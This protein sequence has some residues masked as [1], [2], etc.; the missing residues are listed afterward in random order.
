MRSEFCAIAYG[1][2]CSTSSAS[3]AKYS[4]CGPA[5]R[6][7]RVTV[8]Q[9]ERSRSRREPRPARDRIAERQP[10]AATQRAPSTP[11]IALTSASIGCRASARRDAA[12][13]ARYARAPRRARRSAGAI[14][15]RR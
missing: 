5:A 11:P 10:V 15:P 2:D 3:A 4:T 6:E 9:R 8:R 12:E 14:R 1:A 13:T 7:S